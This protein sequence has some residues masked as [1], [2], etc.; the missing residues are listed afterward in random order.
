MDDAE[1]LSLE[2]IGRFVTASEKIRWKSNS[3]AASGMMMYLCGT[4]IAGS[5]STFMRRQ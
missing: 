5:L 4:Q 1:K 3:A 2:P